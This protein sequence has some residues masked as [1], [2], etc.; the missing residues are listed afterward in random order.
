MS[1]RP[2]LVLGLVLCVA[3]CVQAG[4]VDLHTQ[5]KSALAEGNCTLAAKLFDQI[6]SN[7]PSSFE[8]PDAA[9][10]RGYLAVRMGEMHPED[11]FARVVSAY[12]ATYEAANATKRLAYYEERAGRLD[13]A[14]Q[15][16]LQASASGA[17]GAKENAECL[18]HYAYLD[19]SKYFAAGL[20]DRPNCD[21]SS[22][23]PAGRE[24]EAASRLNAARAK[25]TSAVESLA[26]DPETAPYA[27]FAQA[28][29][30]ETYI[31]EQRWHEGEDAYRAGIDARGEVPQALRALL[32]H[33][34]G[35]CLMRCRRTDEALAELSL[36]LEDSVG[37]APQLSGATVSLQK[38]RADA[39]CVKAMILLGQR[40]YGEATDMLDGILTELTTSGIPTGETREWVGRVAAW[41]VVA[42]HRAGRDTDRDSA[43]S[44]LLD[45]YAGTDAAR[46]AASWARQCGWKHN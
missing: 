24:A 21:G 28:G 13:S 26:T 35:I 1:L 25:F 33:G 39:A 42:L 43:L 7:Y 18:V 31:L 8:A 44:T 16:F 23:I 46:R 9:L 19:V 38:V 5:A 11:L 4:P 30:G 22:A 12:P 2:L 6:L 41:R 36:A 3:L 32:H 45:S 34:L 14:Q 27:A 10:K 37:A 20:P 17:L 29:I 40:Q 15:M